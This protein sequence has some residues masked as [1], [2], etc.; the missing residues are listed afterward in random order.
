MGRACSDPRV[1][2]YDL[3]LP[4]ALSLRRDVTYFDDSSSSQW[5]ILEPVVSR[6]GGRRERSACS[7]MMVRRV[8]PSRTGDRVN[9]IRL[10]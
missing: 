9:I 4:L 6:R 10:S 2:P 7:L 1:V 5:P 8:C 3:C